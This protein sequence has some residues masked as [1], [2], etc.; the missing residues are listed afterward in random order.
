MRRHKDVCHGKQ[1]I[2]CPKCE[3]ILN[4]ANAVESHYNKKHKME[5]VSSKWMCY[6]WKRGTFI[7]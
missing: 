3:M 5:P 1:K 2:D 7:D 6:N 4:T